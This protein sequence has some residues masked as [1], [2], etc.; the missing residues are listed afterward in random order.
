MTADKAR[1]RQVRDRMARTGEPYTEAARR[2]AEDADVATHIPAPMRGWLN[3]P[4]YDDPHTDVVVLLD[5]ATAAAIVELLRERAE[6]AEQAGNY[7]EHRRYAV[8]AA[9]I[10]AARQAPTEADAAGLSRAATWHPGNQAV[11]VFDAVLRNSAR[12]LS[13]TAVA[14][15]AIEVAAAV[16][17]SRGGDDA[18]RKVLDHAARMVENVRET[19]YG[20]G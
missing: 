6:A 12:W 18:K 3:P 11:R 4:K 7:I 20:W 9:D 19:S 8:P 14:G 10:D 1:K 17:W 2:S 13:E 16:A 15:N 5:Q